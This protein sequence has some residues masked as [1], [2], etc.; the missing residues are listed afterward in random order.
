MTDK[1]DG[2]GPDRKINTRVPQWMDDAIHKWMAAYD[3]TES[4][5]VRAALVLGLKALKADPS[6]LG[7]PVVDPDEISPPNLDRQVAVAR[8]GRKGPA[9]K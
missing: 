1:P 2:P 3:R 6:P 4:D 9:K 8:E 5:V 7:R